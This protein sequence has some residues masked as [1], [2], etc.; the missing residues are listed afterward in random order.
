ML[1]DL[2]RIIKTGLNE[3]FRN[4][5]L[6]ISTILIMTM[7]VSLVTIFYFINSVSELIIA[8]IENKVD[9]S[10]YFKEE[11]T[12]SDISNV[13]IEISNIS[14]VSSIVYITKNEVLANFIIQHENDT[15]LI[16]SLT[17]LG[18]NPFLD[19]LNIKT[20]D[21]SQYSPLTNLIETANFSDIID[22][23]DYH[24]R[25]ESIDKI[26]SITA[27]INNIIL[28]LSIVFGFIAVLISF[29]TVKIAIYNSKEEISVMKLVGASNKFVRGP[30]I[31][32]G[33]L[34]GFIAALITFILTF[35]ITYF[36]NSSVN[37]INMFSIFL[38]SFF[39]IILFQLVV[40]IGLGVL[41]SYIAIAKYL[42][43]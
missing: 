25:K 41:S 10:V 32:Q 33:I 23:V 7:V 17:E 28:L 18:Y 30:F 38:N 12:A 42:K 37:G 2:K 34:I 13:Q 43:V 27:G 39:F 15:E 8:D 35:L 16:E 14:E 6:S 9:I 40:G 11:A 29:N 20:W 31:V 19:T 3:F 1:T 24:K 5:T 22:N 36:F 4:I 26:F 21:K